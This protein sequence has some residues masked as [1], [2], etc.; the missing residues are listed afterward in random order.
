MIEAPLAGIL[1]LA[2]ILAAG[3]FLRTVNIGLPSPGDEGIYLYNAREVLLGSRPYTDFFLAH[4]P[5]ETYLIALSYRLFGVGI[6]QGKLEGVLFSVASMPL[7]YMLV[8][9]FYG[10]GEALVATLLFATSYGVIYFT[11]DIWLSAT[12]VFFSILSTYLFLRGRQ[13]GSRMMLGLSGASAALAVLGKFTALPILAT[14]ALFMTFRERDA[15][16]AASV[17]GGFALIIVPAMFLFLSAESIDQTVSYHLSKDAYPLPTRIELAFAVIFAYFPLIFA[18][19]LIGAAEAARSRER[20][21]ADLFLAINALF[22]LA[23]AFNAKYLGILPPAL[24]FIT[25][26]HAFS[27]LAGRLFRKPDATFLFVFAALFLCLTLVTDARILACI[28]S[29]SQSLQEDIDAVNAF[30]LNNS[31]ASD[32]LI[33]RDYKL[34]YVPLLTD[35]RVVPELSDMTDYRM[36]HGMSPQYIRANKGKARYILTYEPDPSGQEILGPLG[37]SSPPM[38]VDVRA[39]YDTLLENATLV[40][41]AGGAN[42]YLNAR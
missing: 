22:G 19:G 27:A 1:V 3:T 6:W 31:K 12:P 23:L 5:L 28:R 13:E 17:V 16:N 40:G 4:P 10:R 21:D 35:R 36:R 32:R 29:E 24:Y 18:Y 7:L 15:K 26:A 42:V 20:T 25:S 33:A 9:R 11:K 37:I 41:K 8:R 34:Y 30:V 39:G 2:A 14:L 38:P